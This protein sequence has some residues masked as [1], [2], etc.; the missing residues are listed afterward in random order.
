MKRML[1]KKIE[2]KSR[3]NDHKSME[4]SLGLYVLQTCATR[5]NDK[6]GIHVSGVRFLTRVDGARVLQEQRNVEITE[7]TNM[8]KIGDWSPDAQLCS[9]GAI[10]D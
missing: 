5:E 10:P 3:K 4:V 7:R 9:P 1:N 8:I 6:N 2:T